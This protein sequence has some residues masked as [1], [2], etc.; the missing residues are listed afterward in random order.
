VG[1]QR[2]LDRHDPGVEFGELGLQLR[3]GPRGLDPIDGDRLEFGAQTRDLSAGHEHLQRAKF[4][5]EPFVAARRF[6]LTFEWAE[7][8]A[9]LAEQVLQPQQV[10]LGG[11]EPTLGLLLALAVLEDSGRLFDDAAPVLRSGVEDRIDL[12]LADDH[13]LL[14]ADAGIGEHLLDV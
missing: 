12:T 1:G 2:R 7:L 3:F 6:C 4:G 11:I 9:H 8:T 14:A 5:D 10:R 13:V